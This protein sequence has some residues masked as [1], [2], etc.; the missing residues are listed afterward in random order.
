MKEFAHPH[1]IMGVLLGGIIGILIAFN[2]YE[3]NHQEPKIEPYANPHAH[4]INQVDVRE[5]L[6]IKTK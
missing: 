1:F 6:P 2:L 3:L 5:R 4:V